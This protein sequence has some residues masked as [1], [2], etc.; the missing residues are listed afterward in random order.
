MAREESDMN[1]RRLLV[2]GIALGAV[3]IA[4]AP[5]LAQAEDA[6]DL[7]RISNYL[8]ATRTL[9]GGFVQIDADAVV[10]EGDFYLRRPGR[11]RFE[12]DAPNPALVIAD[13]FWV[14]VIDKRDGGVDRYPLSETPLDLLL[15]EN[16]DLRREDAVTEIDR[17]N[18]Q[19]AVT[20]RDPEN[21]GMGTITLVFSNTP[22]ELRQWVITDAQGR[23]TTVAL[24]DTRTNVEIPAERFSIEAAESAVRSPQRR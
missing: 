1:R 22:L 5:V 10:S 24:R 3:Q 12:Y 17:S 4:P 7:A 2:A 19:L 18:E 14:G 23:T 11:I 8:N 6:R 16:V 21:R 9:Q 15:R 13:G 20:A